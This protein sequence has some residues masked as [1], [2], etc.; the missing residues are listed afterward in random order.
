MRKIFE[1]TFCYLYNLKFTVMKKKLFFVLVL[2]LICSMVYSQ[3]GKLNPTEAQKETL[4]VVHLLV[5][6]VTG[7]LILGLILGWIQEN[8]RK[9]SSDRFNFKR[10]VI[11]NLIKRAVESIKRKSKGRYPI[12][13]AQHD[14]MWIE[15]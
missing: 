4:G 15:Q 13:K 2:L 9:K 10:T 1:T 12:K 5:I 7:F 8:N 3:I 11:F 14:R 6:I